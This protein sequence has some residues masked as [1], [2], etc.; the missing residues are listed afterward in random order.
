VPVT[1]S[2]VAVA[3]QAPHPHAAMLM[4]D[5]LL[6]KEGQQM[7]QEL[8]YDSARTDLKSAESP[9][10]KLYLTNRPNYIEEFEQWNR[11]YQDVFLKRQR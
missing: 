9:P 6:S 8:G 7:Y 5:F 1:D 3:K 2:G 4:I 10:Q 11:L